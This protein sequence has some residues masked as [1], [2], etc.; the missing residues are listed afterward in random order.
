MVSSVQILFGG[1]FWLWTNGLIVCGIA[2]TAPGLTVGDFLI[3]LG[4]V[5]FSVLIRVEV[6]VDD[7]LLATRRVGDDQLK[8]T[9]FS[10]CHGNK[11]DRHE[12]KKC[13][14]EVFSVERA[15][16]MKFG[17]GILE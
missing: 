3:G 5:V 14:H 11:K 15:R 7:A 9:V 16:L 17:V 4:R 8:R 2:L 10:R 13:S 1:F 6:R 12:V